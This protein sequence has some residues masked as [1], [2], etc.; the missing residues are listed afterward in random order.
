MIWAYQALND[1]TGEGFSHSKEARLDM[2]MDQS[3]SLDAYEIVNTYSYEQLVG[4]FSGMARRSFRKSQREIRRVRALAPIETTTQ[5]TEIIKSQ[6]PQKF[7][8]TG[9]H[10]AKRVF[11]ALR[12]AVN[13]ELGVFERSL[14]QAIQLLGKG[15]R[16]SIITFHSLEDRI[17]KQ[18]FMEYEEGP[19]LP[20]NMPVIPEG[21]EPI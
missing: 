12:I 17:C 2:R 3:R 4:I 7:R 5:L 8:R 20:R 18:M 19:E 11:Q 21:Y 13:D 15:G 10:P 9:G 6:I 1:V 14:E 16:V